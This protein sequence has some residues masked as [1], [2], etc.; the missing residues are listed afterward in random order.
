MSAR[1]IPIY[2]PSFAETLK[3]RAGE[4]Y[5]PSN[6]A[7]GEV[8][9]DAWCC[10]CARDKAMREGADI[11]ECDDNERCDIIANTFAFDVSDTRYPSEWQYSKDGQPMCTAFVEAGQPVP[12]KDEHTA[13]L[14]AE[15]GSA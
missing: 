7:E 14:F 4:K 13:D 12:I 8:F 10:Q 6:G 15:G 1:V 5:R 11:D 2:P 3:A 9:F